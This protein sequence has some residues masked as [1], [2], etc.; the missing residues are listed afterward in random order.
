MWGQFD[1]IVWKTGEN[2][3][4]KLLLKVKYVKNIKKKLSGKFT[5]ML[6]KL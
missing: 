6:A 5:C 2:M 3:L 1:S 4:L